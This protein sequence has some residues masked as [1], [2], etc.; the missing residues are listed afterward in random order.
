[1]WILKFIP[2]WVFYGIFFLGLLGLLTTY[3]LKFIPIPVIRVYQQPIQL[4]AILLVSIG[5]FMSGAVWNENAWKNR[6]AELE[7]QVAETAIKSQEL[8]SKTNA[9][10]I[11]RTKVIKEKSDEIIKVIDREVVKYN[12]TCKLPAEVIKLHNTAAKGLVNE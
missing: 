8:T 11:E 3:L 6:V 4:V 2:D 12:E 9:K 7:K 1:M 5:T 10:Y